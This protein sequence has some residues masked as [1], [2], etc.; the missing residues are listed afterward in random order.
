[1]SC[2]Y[3]D[4]LNRLVEKLEENDLFS[5]FL[6]NDLLIDKIIKIFVYILKE[7]QR[8]PL[9]SIKEVYCYMPIDFDYLDYEENEE[10]TP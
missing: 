4:V 5:K 2:N 1:L 10:E 6:N 3:F 8:Y 9:S 7:Y